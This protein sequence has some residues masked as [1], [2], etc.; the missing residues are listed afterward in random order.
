ML[1]VIHIKKTKKLHAEFIKNSF[2]LDNNQTFG[3]MYQEHNKF[4]R[5]PVFKLSFG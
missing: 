5:A 3:K 1:Y 4:T 2:Y